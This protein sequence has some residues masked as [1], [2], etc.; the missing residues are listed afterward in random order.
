MDF[1]IRLLLNINM[2]S[3]RGNCQN[4]AERLWWKGRS[5]GF[6]FC[7]SESG[8]LVRINPVICVLDNLTLVAKKKQHLCGIYVGDCFGR[9]CAWALS[10][11]WHRL[12]LVTLY[13]V[14]PLIFFYCLWRTSTMWNY[15]D[16]LPVYSFV[17]CLSLPDPYLSPPRK[18]VSNLNLTCFNGVSPAPGQM[19]DTE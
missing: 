3:G 11:M 1:P 12:Y 10:C 15:L 14:N 17:V 7:Y 2:W 9:P 18:S 8:V 16:Y 13:R 6:C 5:L 19:P 4:G